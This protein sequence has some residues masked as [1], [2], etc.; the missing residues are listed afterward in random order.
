MNQQI[1]VAAFLG[2]LFA[3]VTI[4]VIMWQLI[5]WTLRKWVMNK[6]PEIVGAALHSVAHGDMS[7]VVPEGAAN[8]SEM[9]EQMRPPQ[10]VP[11]DLDGMNLK[12]VCRCGAEL[13]VSPGKTLDSLQA[14][15]GWTLLDKNNLVSE[16]R[17]QVCS[18]RDGRTIPTSAA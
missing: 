6:M 17:C 18:T 11:F 3:F 5:R 16:W 15:H 12:I 9:L 2:C 1:F 7:R 14:D 8:L 10:E 4:A 13:V